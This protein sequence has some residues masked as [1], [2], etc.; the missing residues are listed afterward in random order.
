MYQNIQYLFRIKRLK[1]R[2][3]PRTRMQVDGPF[4]TGVQIESI[5]IFKS[6]EEHT[7]YF[8]EIFNYH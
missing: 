7:F 4:H 8:N 5:V 6:L 1:E 2:G 3:G